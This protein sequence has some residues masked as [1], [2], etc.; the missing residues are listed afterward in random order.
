[1][2]AAALCGCR[3]RMLPDWSHAD[4]AA[5]TGIDRDEDFIEAEREEPGCVIVLS[6]EPVVVKRERLLAA[7]REAQ[8]TGRANQLSEDHVKWTFID[9]IAEATRDP[10]RVAGPPARPAPPAPPAYPAGVILQRRSA[11]ALDGRSS[12]DAPTF[13]GMLS[14]VMP[15]D[16]PPWDALWWDARI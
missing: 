14:R 9:E 5:L 10:G 1:R 8:W 4:I 6:H 3:A 13:F 16:A 15:H 2:I 12:I 7:V 11:V